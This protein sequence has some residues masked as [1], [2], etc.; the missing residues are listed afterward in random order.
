M[1]V[2][3]VPRLFLRTPSPSI[4]YQTKQNRGGELQWAEHGPVTSQI[5]A[6]IV[7]LVLVCASAFWACFS[8]PLFVKWR[9]LLCLS[10]RGFGSWMQHLYH[11]PGHSRNPSGFVIMLL[12]NYRHGLQGANILEI[13]V[14]VFLGIRRNVLISQLHQ[15][16]VNANSDT[17]PISLMI[18]RLK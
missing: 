14:V 11:I 7:L 15:Q 16:F 18:A 8:V 9:Y 3:A 4:F 13:N 12:P 6:Q 10:L 17:F 1:Y 2:K 5:I